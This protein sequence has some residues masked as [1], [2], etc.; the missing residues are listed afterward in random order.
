MVAT[1]INCRN[2]WHITKLAILYSITVSRKENGNRRSCA[3]SQLSTT[4]LLFLNACGHP[5]NDYLSLQGYTAKTVSKLWLFWVGISEVSCGTE[6]RCLVC[7]YSSAARSKTRPTSNPLLLL[8]CLTKWKSCD[9]HT[10]NSR[11]AHCHC[12]HAPT[13][14]Q[15]S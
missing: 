5:L 13:S 15:P 8:S 1:W 4:L 12:W 6:A 7:I 11:W 14:T 10:C 2:K 9:L 3:F